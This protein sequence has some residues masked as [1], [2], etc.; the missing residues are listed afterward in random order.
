MSKEIKLSDGKLA[1]I[2]DGKGLDLLNAQKKAKT[3]DEIPYALIAEL[4]EIDGNYLVYEDI[5]E[6]PIEDVILLQEAIGG[7]LQSKASA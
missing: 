2:K 3:S 1:V 6:L 4:T 5:L 7:K